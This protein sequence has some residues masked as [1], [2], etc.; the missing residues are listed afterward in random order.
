MDHD[1]SHAP[2]MHRRTA[3]TP[4]MA[5]VHMARRDS[6]SDAARGVRPL[7]GRAAHMRQC[8]R[9]GWGRLGFRRQFLG[10]LL[11]ATLLSTLG[12]VAVV[13][14][15]T[16]ASM[17]DATQARAARDVQVARQTL[18]TFGQ[19]LALRDGQLFTDT[20]YR[21]NGD[22][23]MVRQVT[24]LTGE[25]AVV[26]EAEGSRLLSVASDLPMSGAGTSDTGGVGAIGDP[27]GGAAYQALRMGCLASPSVPPGRHQGYRG[28]ATV[29]GNTY[30]TAILP[31]DDAQGLCVGAL[32]VATPVER[33]DASLRLLVGLLLLI[34]LA[35]TS[36]FIVVGYCISAPVSRH[37]FATLSAGL[38]NVG[39]SSARLE[40]LTHAQVGRTSRQIA[41]ARQL[42]DE[43]RALTEVASALEHGVALLRDSTGSIWAELSYPGAAPDPYATSR[44][45][46]QTAV[47]ASQIGGATQQA[48]ALC[49]RLRARMNQVIAEADVL[50]ENGRDIAAEARRLSSAVENLQEA[51]GNRLGRAPSASR[52]GA[53][54]LRAWLGSLGARAMIYAQ[55]VLSDQ[56]DTD[57]D[58]DRGH[59]AHRASDDVLWS[60]E[61][62]AASG[63]PVTS[64]Y[65][66][67]APRPRR[68]GRP[69]AQADLRLSS[70]PLPPYHAP[71]PDGSRPDTKHPHTSGR[72]HAPWSP[73]EVDLRADQGRY[74]AAQ[75]PDEV[76]EPG[77]YGSSGFRTGGPARSPRL[78]RGSAPLAGGGDWMNDQL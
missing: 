67:H 13:C 22:M 30:L 57:E 26:Y 17:M 24:A 7:D 20:G 29:L 78:A 11:A 63:H 70:L 34:G 75:L 74:A 49:Q 36:V 14:V 59:P 2:R 76:A 40:G 69:S 28:V 46:R 35:V 45:A 61:H 8:M 47:A 53:L 48:A 58:E 56:G 42:A 21:V 3:E 9:R 73:E 39:A 16:R 43:Q 31:L 19:T 41:T 15:F 65:A 66:S 10:L 51:L 71:W 18:G 64:D 68:T 72:D 5:G 44:A 38:D 55:S 77:A 27:L 12:T 4:K 37:A 33:V 52:M 1:A 25:D 23:A 50:G 32:M 60:S 54:G 62:A 6:Q